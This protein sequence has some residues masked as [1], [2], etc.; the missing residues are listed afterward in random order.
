ME[1]EI[2]TEENIPLLKEKLEKINPKNILVVTGSASYES[3]GAKS[4][5]EKIFINRDLIYFN[6]FKVNP[7]IID[8]K[9]GIS[10]LKNTE[11]HF[12]VAIGGGSVI[13]MAKLIKS[14]INCDL[15]LD[16]LIKS[17]K[18]FS[19][20]KI[21]F[22]AIPTT[23]GSGSES[24]HFAALYINGLKYSVSHELMLPDFALLIPSLTYNTPH[25][26]TACCGADAL[27]QAI[28]SYWS[29]NSTEESRNYAKE[30][31]FLLWRFLP[32]AIMN[33]IE[34]R[35]KVLTASNISGK[36]I[37]ISFT[38]APHAYSYGLTSFHSIPHGHAVSLTLPYFF[39]LN[40]KV[41]SDNCNDSRGPA[42]VKDK[43]NDLINFIDSD[44]ENAPRK[45]SRFFNLIFGYI[46]IQVINK[47]IFDDRIKLAKIINIDRLQNNPVKI[48]QKDIENMEFI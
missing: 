12:I 8:I 15:F 22:L 33:D 16:D 46:H 40:L 3:S 36:A 14:Y 31:F 43:M 26:L 47:I 18:I 24:T 6:D 5:I 29:V 20:N 44:A 19:D 48:S 34:A 13:D 17:N 41:S 2:L 23:A 27:S 30:A 10:L 32:K 39:D 45:L 4:L 25:Y 28:E 42:F 9:K 1:Q 21:P 37:N 7:D 11:I 38:T 35:N